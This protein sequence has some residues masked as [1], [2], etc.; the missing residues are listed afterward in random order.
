MFGSKGRVSTPQRVLVVVLVTV[1]LGGIAV[2]GVAA[3]SVQETPQDG[4]QTAEVRL[5]HASPDAPGVDVYVDGDPA[6]ENLTF[7]NATDYV[8]LDPGMHNVTI[9]AA[10]DPSNVVFQQ[11]IPVKPGQYTIAAAGEI[12]EDAD[13]EFQPVLLVD[14]A[15]P[16]DNES[17][18]RLAHLSPDAPTV[19]VTV[20]ETGDVLFD[21][22]SYANATA[23]QTVPEGDYT[24][25]VRAATPNNDGEVVETINA[26]VEGGEAYTAI[27]TGYLN[28][29]EAAGNESFRVL[30]LEDMTADQA[31]NET[32]TPATETP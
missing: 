29:D 23:Y 26:T 27:A 24:L 32:A 25:E 31:T 20:A 11:D 16:A 3:T 4:N 2:A 19:D 17:A 1:A 10:G 21:N 8:E 15:A 6:V 12:S 18:V 5:V 9:T 22:V 13:R 14:D 7:G 28:P 30:V